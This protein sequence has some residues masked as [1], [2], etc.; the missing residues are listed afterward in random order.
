MK[1]AIRIVS[2]VT[3]LAAASLGTA[4]AAGADR[5]PALSESSDMGVTIAASEATAHVGDLVTYTIT[6]TDWSGNAQGAFVNDLLPASMSLV[7]ATA[8]PDATGDVATATVSTV[9]DPSQ[10]SD[11]TGV[12]AG[13][14]VGRTLVVFSVPVLGDG[15]FESVGDAETM[16]IVAVATRAGATMNEAQVG[17][18]NPD[19]N[20]ADNYARAPVTFS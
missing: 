1:K 17:A 20:T 9:T 8:T 7:S 5:G 11:A 12:D 14:Y 3:A 19:P 13:P 6:A 16:Q 15:S 2:A 18:L 10:F 4:V